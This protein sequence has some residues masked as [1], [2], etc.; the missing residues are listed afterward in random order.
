MLNP[1]DRID[2]PRIKDKPRDNTKTS[3]PGSTAPITV[4]NK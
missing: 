1:D 2:M 3:A 4:K